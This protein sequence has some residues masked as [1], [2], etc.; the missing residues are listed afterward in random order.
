MPCPEGEREIELV[1]NRDFSRYTIEDQNHLLEA[2]RELLCIKENVK[3]TRVRPGS[4]IITLKIPQEFIG[5]LSSLITSG[6]LARYDVVGIFL[7]TSSSNMIEDS[8]ERYMIEKMK[9]EISDPTPQKKSVN[10]DQTANSGL[11]R[12]KVKWFNA[13]KGYGFIEMDN[14]P[15]I[16]VQHNEIQG[17]GFKSLDK[18]DEVEFI[19]DGAKKTEAHKVE[20]IP[21]EDN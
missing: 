10:I 20:R 8:F 13:Q 11:V 4:V 18:G 19:L 2:I 15:D 6:R 5:K 16:F 7:K 3:I 14:G 12:G 21:K 9:D 1:I 17:K